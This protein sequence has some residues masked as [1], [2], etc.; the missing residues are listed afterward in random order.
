MLHRHRNSYAL[1]EK[2]EVA[3]LNLCENPELRSLDLSAELAGT[4]QY[5]NVSGSE[6]LSKV[7]CPAN[8]MQVLKKADFSECAL[9]NIELPGNYAA[10]VWLDLRKNKMSRV[11]MPGNYPVL[12]YLDLS[13]NQ[14]SG[15]FA[16]P[17][18]L[19]N[20]KYLYLNEN[21]LEQIDFGPAMRRIETLQLRNNKLTVLPSGLPSL[22][23]LNV[24]KNQLTDMEPVLSQLERGMT[25]LGKENPWERPPA[26]TVEKGRGAILDYFAEI[27]RGGEE[28]SLEAKLILIGEAQAGKT[29]LRTRLLH[30]EQALP[31]KADRTKGLDI[32]IEKYSFP[33]VGGDVMR[34]NVFD[35]GG[36]DHYK[37]LHQ[38]FYSRRALYVLVTKNGDESNDF[39]FWFDTAQLFGDG[40]PVLVVNNLFGDVRS[41]FNRGKYSRFDAI[42]KDPVDTNLLS[43]AGWP[44]AKKRME[45]L[46]ETLPHVQQFVPKTWANVRRELQTRHT[47]NVLPLSEFLKICAKPE[48]GAM[49]KNRALRCSQYLHDIG[50]CLHYQDDENLMRQVIVKNEWATD[51]VYRVL[52]DPDIAARQGQFDW[53]DLRR[54][55]AADEYENLRPELFALMKKFRLCYALPTGHAF[56][57]PTLLPVRPPEGYIWQT[58]NNL[59]MFVGYEFMPPGLMS[60]LIVQLHAYIAEGKHLVWRDGVV[61]EWP[62]TRAEVTLAKRTGRQT[63]RIRAKG[64]ERRELLTYITRQLDAL[65]QIFGTGLKVYKEIPC[66]CEHCRTLEEPH[67]FDLAKVEK[68]RNDGR[69]VIECDISYIEVP[70][71]SLLN[72]VFAPERTAG[73]GLEPPT[74]RTGPVKLF[75]SYSHVDEPYKD[76]F[77]KALAPYWRQDKLEIWDDRQLLAGSRFEEEIFTRLNDADIVCLLVSPDFIASDYCFTKEMEAALL[78]FDAGRNRVAPII[79]RPTTGWND[80]KI[81]QLTAGNTD[82]KAVSE[83]A[84]RDTAW[85]DVAAHIFKL[86]DNILKNRSN[87]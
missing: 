26:E 3:A 9:E 31:T 25:L 62:N 29:S 1:N 40:S 14:L 68:R 49:D 17:S 55:W 66:N 34:L 18:S 67:F 64:P 58:E 8:G 32:E 50:I 23:M 77:K 76:V 65:H 54:I 43:L 57:A 37:P 6:N 69:A 22:D 46:A 73:P 5:L 60:Q 75:I 19:D 52:D 59:H 12:E 39:D 85:A 86:V 35:F 56:V 21:Q 71:E 81:G 2:G 61:L 42:L 82:A 15:A 28:K 70:I 4:L 38:F 45:Q 36:Q 48:N 27:R 10:L 74:P 44:E 41:Q 24:E 11:G 47:E 53:A 72:G 78:R 7:T 33:L 13:D 51:A 80:F 83:A 30:P 87:D 20:L 63:I 16:V 84:N 79:I